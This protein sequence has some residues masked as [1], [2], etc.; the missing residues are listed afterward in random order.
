M[1]NFW[2]TAPND[3]A[4]DSDLIIG[5]LTKEM[6]R[7]VVKGRSKGGKYRGTESLT[8]NCTDNF[9][10]KEST[11]QMTM[12]GNSKAECSKQEESQ[13]GERVPIGNGQTEVDNTVQKEDNKNIDTPMM[14][15]R[16]ADGETVCA[17]FSSSQKS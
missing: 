13:T 8:E 17:Y 14:Q 3:I 4:K 11:K 7:K 2:Q 1:G 5:N 9:K 12:K 16:G 6:M 10:G 15:K